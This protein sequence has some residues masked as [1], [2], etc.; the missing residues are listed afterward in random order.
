MILKKENAGL[1]KYTSSSQ[2]LELSS[3]RIFTSI[4]MKKLNIGI[5]AEHEQ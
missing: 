1:H 4:Q 3:A 5:V 2:Q